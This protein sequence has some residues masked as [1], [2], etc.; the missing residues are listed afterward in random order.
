MIERNICVTTGVIGRI[1]FKEQTMN[2]KDIKKIIEILNVKKRNDLALLLYNADSDLNISS[3]YGSY[4]RSQL[5]IFLIYAPLEQYHKL[6][7]LNR[8][9]Y[10]TLR[11]TVLDIHP[12]GD[13]SPEI[14]SVDFRIKWGQ[15][16]LPADE[17]IEV[18]SSDIGMKIFVSYSNNDKARAGKLKST[19]ENYGL[20]VFLAHEDIEPTTEWQERILAELKSCDV[21]IPLLTPHFKASNW[22]GQETGIADGNKKLIIPLKAGLNPFGFIA[23]FQALNFNTNNLAGVR[24]S[25]LDIMAEKSDKNKLIESLIQ[26]L[27]QSTSFDDANEKTQYLRKMQDQ[28]NFGQVLKIIKGAF[29]N[30]QVYHGHESAPFIGNLLQSNKDRLKEILEYLKLD[31][32][33][34]DNVEDNYVLNFIKRRFKVD[35][36]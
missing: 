34:G 25:I 7:S 1:Y 29:H 11:E 5:S 20:N 8:R 3:Q 13:D 32:Q 16:D 22:T 30:S 14:T 23:R 10:K 17:N 4:T 15:E 28:L 6:K 21:F 35:L 33:V 31:L 9:D 36:G 26:G 12:P 19:L 27:S 2:D 18:S 24:K